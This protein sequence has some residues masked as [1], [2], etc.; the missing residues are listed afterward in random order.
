MSDQFR[1]TMARALAAAA[2]GM[3]L[4]AALASGA[5]AQT[6]PSSAE[7]GAAESEDIVVTARR[8]VET[9]Q[10]TPASV[11]SISANPQRAAWIN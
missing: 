1:S 10:G 3:V 6:A 7:T 4:S 2:S 9:V 11:A 8:R 5:A